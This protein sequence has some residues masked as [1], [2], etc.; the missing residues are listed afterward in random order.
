VTGNKNSVNLISFYWN[1]SYTTTLFLIYRCLIRIAQLSLGTTTQGNC[2][3][4]IAT[5]EN[6]KKAK[7]CLDKVDLNSLSRRCLTLYYIIE[8]DLFRN[9]SNITM[10]TESAQ[11]ALN[12]AQEDSYGIELH[13]A[14]SR[15][16][17]L[18]L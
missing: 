4:S 10:A 6:I 17:A 16:Q 8:S 9:M 1:I 7:G 12:I 15:L 3:F 2:E 5:P 11:K 13:S 14:Q 18:T